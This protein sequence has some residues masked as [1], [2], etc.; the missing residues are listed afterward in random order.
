LERFAES[1]LRG[2]G[3][4]AETGEGKDVYRKRRGLQKK[5][6]L[7]QRE[8]GSLATGDWM[9]STRERGG[10]EVEGVHTRKRPPHYTAQGNG[11]LS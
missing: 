1:S 4:A 8:A 5:E 2:L 9:S 10:K 6:V 11:R 3:N 7:N